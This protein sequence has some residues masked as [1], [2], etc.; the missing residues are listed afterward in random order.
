[1]ASPDVASTTA[2]LFTGFE[3]FRVPSVEDLGIAFQR[4]MVSVDANVL[5][6]LYRYSDDYGSVGDANAE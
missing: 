1:V 4:A 3:G 5:L 2:G 6:D